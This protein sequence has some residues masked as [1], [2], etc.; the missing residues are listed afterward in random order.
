MKSTSRFQRSASV[1]VILL[2]VLLTGCG[3][4]SGTTAAPTAPS[5]APSAASQGIMLSASVG[6]ATKVDMSWVDSRTQGA[7]YQ[8]YRNGEL[9][10]TAAGSDGKAYDTGLNPS[11]QYCYQVTAVN[12]SGVGTAS[13]NQSCVKTAPLAG[14]NIQ[15]IDQAPPL[16]LALDAQGRE[17]VSFCGSKGVYYQASQGDGSIS[18]VSLDPTASCFNALLVVGSDGSNHIIYVDNNSDQ[19]KYATD[20]SGSWII[21]VVPGAD[22]AEFYSLAIDNGDAIHVAYLLFTG[23]APNCYQLNY[24]SNASGSW[25]ISLVA[26]A[27]AYPSIAVDGHGTPHLAYEDTSGNL[28]YASHSSAKWNT[29][30]VDTEGT[31]NQIKID[32]DL[33]GHAH[34]VYGNAQNLYSKLAVSP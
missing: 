29:V 34:I 15:V 13:S 6:S 27:L 21:D 8:I 17:R 12:A 5:A 26:N 10:T 23:Q 7:K 28:K 4:G 32:L 30:Y 9:T 1:A 16:S 25:Q 31:Q 33:A 22:G 20:V 18:T 14:W 2:P 11:T 19:L 24:A 3:G